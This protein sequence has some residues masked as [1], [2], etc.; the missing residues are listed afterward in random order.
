MAILKVVVYPNE[1]L[2]QRAEPYGPIGP[3]T[4][5]LAQDMLETMYASE[6]VGLAGPQ[7]GVSK[8]IF[9]A[10]PPEGKPMVFINPEIYERQG[11]QVGEEGCLSLPELYAPVERAARIRVRAYDARGRLHDIKAS[12]FLA[13]IVQ[14][15]TDHLD[16][17]CFVE[18]LDLANAH[19]EDAGMA[20]DPQPHIGF[21]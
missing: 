9:V 19:G 20:R 6:G 4:A 11:S 18:R 5:K 12:G 15:E 2:R 7:I 1:P 10:H 8:R 14:H 16:G 17:I 21:G 3:E 13:R